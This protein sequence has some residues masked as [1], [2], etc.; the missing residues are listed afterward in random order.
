MSV[1]IDSNLGMK[2]IISGTFEVQVQEEINPG[3][4]ALSRWMFSAAAGVHDP[5]TCMFDC[6]TL[7]NLGLCGSLQELSHKRGLAQLRTTALEDN[8]NDAADVGPHM[9]H[10]RLVQHYLSLPSLPS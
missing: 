9:I 3:H 10:Q 2:A 4:V 1:R 6:A 7:S 8:Q 5:E